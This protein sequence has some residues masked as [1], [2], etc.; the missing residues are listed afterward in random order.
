MSDNH[1]LGPNP[2]LTGEVDHTHLLSKD[3]GQLYQNKEYSDVTLV[4]EGVEFHAHKVILAARSEYFRA[5]LYGG[6]RESHQSRIELQET[7]IGAFKIIVKYIYTGSLMLARLKVIKHF[8]QL[9]LTKISEFY[10]YSVYISVAG[11]SYS[12][13][14]RIGS[15][16]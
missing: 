13:Y 16:L 8:L 7:S 9:I 2:K 15:P 10:I 4:V 14:P 12:G 11:G 6:M 3:I 5:L 1:H